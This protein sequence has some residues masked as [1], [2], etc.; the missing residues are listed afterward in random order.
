MDL[1]AYI[2]IE[3]LDSIAEA[4]GIKVSRLRGYRLMRDQ[5]AYSDAE[6]L[7][8]EHYARMHA[9]E[10]ALSSDPPFTLNP[11]GYGWNDATRRREKKYLIKDGK[12]HTIGF[13]MEL[14]HGKRRKAVKYEV[15]R[16]VKMQQTQMS[17]WNKYAGREDVLYIHARLGSWNWSGIQW[18]YYKNEAW[19][20]DGCDDIY[21]PSYCDIYARIDPK[22]IPG[23]AD[24]SSDSTE[25][26]VCG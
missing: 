17:L 12:D 7:E 25:N 5:A 18:P 21:D 26:E 24:G 22:T 3:D 10:H 6:L 8:G 23:K 1:G 4:N 19:F 20:L 15:K 16:F 9:Y 13:R 2:Q 11:Q 14:L